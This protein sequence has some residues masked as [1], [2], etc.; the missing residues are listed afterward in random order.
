MN[1]DPPDDDPVKKKLYEIHRDIREGHA[2]LHNRHDNHDQQI[3]YIDSKLER[4]RRLLVAAL[5]FD[6]KAFMEE[7]HR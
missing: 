1:D 5:R 3:G 6:G 2:S 7:W 4:I